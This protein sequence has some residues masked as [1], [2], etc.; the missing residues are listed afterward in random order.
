MFLDSGFGW[1]HR[2]D[3]LGGSVVGAL[4]LGGFLRVDWRIASGLLGRVG[5]W[6]C[7]DAGKGDEAL[8]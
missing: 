8:E 2:L 4:Y 1:R 3:F 5:D 6:S 7:E